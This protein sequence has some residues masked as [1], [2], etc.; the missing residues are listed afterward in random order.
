MASVHVTELKRPYREK[1]L[2]TVFYVIKIITAQE[3]INPEK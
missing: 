2:D 3:A 1:S